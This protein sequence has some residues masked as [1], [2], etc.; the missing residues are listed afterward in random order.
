[1]MKYECR[2]I[3]PSSFILHPSSFILHPFVMKLTTLIWLIFTLCLLLVLAAMGWLSATALRLDRAEIES[4]RLAALEEKV[5]LALWRMDSALAPTVALESARP[6]FAYLAYFPADRSFNRMFNT[7]T[8]GE[9]LVA[10]PLLVET[11]PRIL[12]H[13]QIDAAGNLTSPQLPVETNRKLENAFK[14][15]PAVQ[16]NREKEFARLQKLISLQKIVNLLPVPKPVELQIVSSSA[17]ATESQSS[18][19][20][21]PGKNKTSVVPEQKPALQNQFDS[22]QPQSQS[23]YGPQELR[24]QSA[25]DYQQREQTVQ[26]NASAMAMNQL[27]NMP[28]ASSVP[29]DLPQKKSD[30][31]PSPNT[32]MGGVLMTPLWIDGNLILARRVLVAGQEYVQGCMLDWP[33]IRSWLKTEIADLLPG[34]E[35]VPAGV[36]DT[37]EESR[38]LAALPI[39]LVP[40]AVAIV[41]EQNWSPL[42]IS[43]AAAWICLLM[44]AAAIV[45][46][47]TGVMRLSGRRASFVTAVTHELRTPLTTFQMYAEML[48]EDMV[49]EESQRKE[50]LK[51]LRSEA[52]RLTH[53]VE[54]VLAYA[55]LERGRLDR[56]RET[57]ALGDLIG[58]MQNRLADRASQARMELL[59]ESDEKT[60]SSLV[61]T[62]ISAVEQILFN[63]IDNACKY[64]ASA[65][66]IRIHLI[67]QESCEHAIVRIEDHGPGIALEMRRRLFHSFSKTAKEAAHS[68]PGVGLGLALSRRLARDL[69]GE[70]SFDARHSPGARFILALPLA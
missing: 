33:G 63:L 10:S 9:M 35:L 20:R 27:A 12:L 32:D 51:T 41:G 66:D 13:F 60:D 15:D 57:I 39:R 5:R 22:Q 46:L 7:R 17:A 48:A 58:S 30:S 37:A 49:P 28:P 29:A 40:G 68:A 62:N 65:E 52:V 67:L 53:L 50:Y 64:A 23:A 43:L 44:T 54:N 18:K 47:L 4:R 14:L 11:P 38:L 21:L 42:T 61:K 55:R 25:R 69:G 3:H 2:A 16:A 26:Q 31:A 1:M 45:G 59:V 6:Y 70:L 19:T 56:R 34:A 24:S 36:S 8:K